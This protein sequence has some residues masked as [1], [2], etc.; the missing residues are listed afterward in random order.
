MR[1]EVM[2]GEGMSMKYRFETTLTS[3]ADVLLRRSFHRQFFGAVS[4]TQTRFDL[5]SSPD[6]QR[7][8]NH[9]ALSH[10]PCG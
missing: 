7:R 1:S 4:L 10:S 6:L 5:L 9:E 8:S 2:L 3:A